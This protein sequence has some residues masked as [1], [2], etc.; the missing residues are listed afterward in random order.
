MKILN[1]LRS[2]AKIRCLMGIWKGP[3]MDIQMS[4]FPFVSIVLICLHLPLH[5]TLIIQLL[6][7]STTH[8]SIEAINPFTKV[9][10]KGKQRKR[11]FQESE[12]LSGTP[13]ETFTESKEKE[14]ASKMEG[15]AEWQL[16]GLE[17]AQKKE[18]SGG[19]KLKS[20]AKR[21]LSPS[22]P[23]TSTSSSAACA[24]CGETFEDDWIQC[25]SCLEWWHEDSSSWE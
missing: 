11:K 20:R 23:P 18:K 3:K 13:Y 14:K 16:K 24:G 10:V 22:M 5:N 8:T 9:P 17:A 2:L 6:P 7:E 1:H 25:E 15:K 4:T 12:I 19:L 21:K